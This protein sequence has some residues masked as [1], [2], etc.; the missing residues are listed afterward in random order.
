[1]KPQ[2]ILIADDDEKVVA[3]LK[4]SLQKEGYQTTE[5]YNGATALELAKKQVPDLILADVTMP[6]MDGF[7]LCK[8]IRDDDTTMHI[9]FIFLTAKGELNDKVTGLNLG[10]DDY[11]SKPFHIS[12][13]TARIKSILQRIAM[14]SQH[15]HAQEE[16]DLKG[17]LEQMHLPEVIQTLSMNQKTGGL[18]INSG[19]RSGKIYFEN[20][21]VIQALLGQ[22]KGEEALYR[23]LVWD[24]GTFEFDTSDAP[25]L[26]PIGKTTTSLLMEGFEERDE[27]F[28]YKKAMPS[29]SFSIKIVKSSSEEIKPTTQKVLGLIDGQRTIQEIIEQSSLNYLLTTKILYTMLKK[30]LIEAKE[31]LV[32][33]QSHT[34]DYGQLAHELY[35]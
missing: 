23:I 15:P 35:D 12:E 5:A 22:I 10:A 7:E 6:E 3:L 14:L 30:G 34:K 1:M 11:I 16:S 31:N 18:K 2:H 20:G 19:N 29:F 8:H 28:K 4:S 9:P 26:P 24:E 33:T 27:F 17:N 13:V 21:E 32:L 25:A